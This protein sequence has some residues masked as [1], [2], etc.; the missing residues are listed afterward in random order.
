M[1][2][3]S[4]H[5][6]SLS[7][8][9]VLYE[10]N[11]LIAVW[12]TPGLL[13]QPDETGRPNLMDAVQSW[14]KQAYNKPGKVFIGCLHRLDREVGGIV[15]FA[16]T[17]KGASRLS[18]QFRDRTIGKRYLAVVAGKPDKAE[19]QLTHYWEGNDRPRQIFEKA[20]PG[21]KEAR[22]EYKVLAHENECSLLEI[23]LH[24]G[25]KHQIR[26]QLAKIGNPILGDT[27]Y[28]GPPLKGR[29]D[30]I[31]LMAYELS[32]T[33][34]TGEQQVHLKAASAEKWKK[35]FLKCPIH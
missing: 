35:E 1:S 7:S 12:K 3:S 26:A 4:T 5:S 16:K 32:F 33:K 22:L 29:S 19:G 11:H 28:G 2:P 21:L 6:T 23:K 8:S 25:R 18:A 15:L 13:T 10:D 31:A 17:S 34:A 24:T 27:R 14:L 30:E 20:R 9:K